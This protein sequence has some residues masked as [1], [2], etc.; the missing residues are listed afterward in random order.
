MKHLE[1][2]PVR[3]VLVNKQQRKGGNSQTVCHIEHRLSDSTLL[4]TAWRRFTWQS[5]AELKNSLLGK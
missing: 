5:G 2:A 1:R 4:V 3:E